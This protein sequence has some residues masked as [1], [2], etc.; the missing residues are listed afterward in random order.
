MILLFLLLSIGDKCLFTK[1]CK[2]DDLLSFFP[3]SW[4]NTLL[5]CPLS[6]VPPYTIF[7]LPGISVHD[8]ASP[9]S[10]IL[11]NVSLATSGRF[12]CEVSGGPP[13]SVDWYLISSPQLAGWHF[14]YS[15]GFPLTRRSPRSRLL[16]RRNTSWNYKIFFKII[17]DLPKS[18]PSIR[19]V[20]SRHGSSP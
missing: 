13:R 12:K 8:Q 19:G 16:V 6:D 14:L 1:Q 20:V 15:T 18:G 10:L 4:V 11:Q 3:I 17:L 7:L 2:R 9:S 5:L